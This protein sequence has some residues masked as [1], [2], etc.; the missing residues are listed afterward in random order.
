MRQNYRFHETQNLNQ[1]M[2]TMPTTQLEKFALILTQLKC[3]LE[4]GEKGSG[5]E[6][7]R[8]DS[9]TK[10]DHCWAM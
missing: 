4:G 2:P 1:Q 5:K 3:C 10:S 8:R 6:R 9:S 7:L